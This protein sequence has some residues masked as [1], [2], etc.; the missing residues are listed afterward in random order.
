M[1]VLHQWVTIK[2]TAVFGGYREYD[3]QNKKNELE[4]AFISINQFPIISMNISMN[5]WRRAFIDKLAE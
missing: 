2:G 4:T 3:R 5:S 1:L